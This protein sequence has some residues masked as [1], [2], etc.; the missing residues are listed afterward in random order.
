MRSTVIVSI[1]TL[2]KGCQRQDHLSRNVSINLEK[3][4]QIDQVYILG[5]QSLL[6]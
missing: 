1:M 2:T 4:Q 6:T 3:M 5:P